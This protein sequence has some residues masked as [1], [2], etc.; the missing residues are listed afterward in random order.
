MNKAINLAASIL[1]LTMMTFIANLYALKVFILFLLI[2]V[3]KR[4]P[5]SRP[6]FILCSSLCITTILQVIVG[7]FRQTAYPLATVT[8]GLIWPV[9]SLLIAIPLLRSDNKFRSFTKILFVGHSFLVIYDLLYAASVIWHFYMP[10]IEPT[11]EIPFS[12]YGFTSRMNFDNLNVL[13]FTSPVF[14]F[15][16]FI[17]YDFK[18]NRMIQVVILFLDFTLLI[19]CGR[20]SLMLIFILS[21]LVALLFGNLVQKEIRSKIYKYIIVIISVVLLILA[22]LYSLN[23]DNFMGYVDT[24]TKA[25]DSNQEPIK[26]MQM[27]SLLD[28]FYDNPI[29]GSGGGAMIWDPYRKVYMYRVELMYF[30]Q[31]ANGGIVVFFFYSIS[32]F[33]TLLVGLY[34]A[35]KYKDLLFI[36]FLIGYFFIL[37][38]NG[39]NPVLCSF[40]LMLPLYICYAKINQLALRK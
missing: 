2:I 22:Y 1:V 3:L 19:L 35:R 6:V 9:L 40:D 26:Y 15:L 32:I 8:V 13:T 12:F 25:F 34:Y 36:S 11:V 7:V 28:V 20:R 39:T 27:Q 4:C 10:N 16:F 18:V 24:F 30:L 5:I 37:I 23:S 33:G 31:L 17:K 38:A 14:L 29:W 21:P